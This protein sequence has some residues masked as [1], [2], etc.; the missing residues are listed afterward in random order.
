MK[1]IDPRKALVLG[2]LLIITFATGCAGAQGWPHN[3]YGDS[4]GRGGGGGGF[5]NAYPNL[6]GSAGSYPHNSVYGSVNA[7]NHGEHKSG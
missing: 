7:L 2:G 5:G 1:A 6:D 3:R 4:G